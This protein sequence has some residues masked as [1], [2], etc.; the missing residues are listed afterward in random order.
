M[1]AASRSSETSAQTR[2]LPAV[3]SDRPVIENLLE[4]YIHDLSE[5][6]GIEIGPDGRFGYPDLDLY[7]SQPDDRHPFLI[8]ESERLAGL[9]LVRR[10]SP[11]SDD[12]H[13][14]DVAELFVLRRY[15]RGG[16]GTRAAHALWD[17][18]PGRWTVRV[19]A[20]NSGAV[21]F[22]RGA[23]SAYT[24]GCFDEREVERRAGLWHVLELQS[25]GS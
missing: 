5:P 11:E 22:W 9:A 4:L 10:G 17:R 19:L 12:P 23:V 13:T 25:C 7:W 6:F 8:F 14:L 1:D 20:R 16:V 24:R 18:L 3:L 2:I 21:A 15:R